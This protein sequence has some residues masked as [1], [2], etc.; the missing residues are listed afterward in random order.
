M[1]VHRDLADRRLGLRASAAYAA[2]TYL[3][4]QETVLAASPRCRDVAG[5]AKSRIDQVIHGSIALPCLDE[6]IVVSKMSLEFC[7]PSHAKNWRRANVEVEISVLRS[8]LPT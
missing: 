3:Y 6:S 5:L 1:R 4:F 2:M 7:T 8:D